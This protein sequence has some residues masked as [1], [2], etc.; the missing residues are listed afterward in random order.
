MRVVLQFLEHA[1]AVELRHQD[2]EQHQVDLL[3]DRAAELRELLRA[4][5]R[6]VRLQRVGGP[7]ELFAVL[8]LERAPEAC[9]QR[10]GIREEGLDD[11]A[12]EVV[13]AEVAQV[14]ERAG[15]EAGPGL[16]RTGGT[17]PERP[18][19]LQRR[20]QLVGSDRLR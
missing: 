17:V 8:L 5:R 1:V 12:E 18:R 11:L 13:A 15:V 4:E 7:A 9:D 3:L 6:A 16:R 19:A 20:R 10:R 2:I 14:L